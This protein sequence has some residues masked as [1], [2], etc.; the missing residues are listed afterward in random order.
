MKA[1]MIGMALGAALLFAGSAA[2]A[3]PS[4]IAT[5]CAKD[6]KSVCGA[7][8]PGG[9]KL[10]ACMKEHFS[11]LSTDCQIAM[12]KAAAVGRACKAD[13]TKYCGDVKPGQGSKAQCLRS[14]SA[15][16]SAGCKEAMAKAEA[17]GK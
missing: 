11:Q 10:A 1:G 14:H 15:V 17:G 2:H 9:G 5:A 13:M 16:L 6:V 3:A 12:V 4:A 8:K 7:V